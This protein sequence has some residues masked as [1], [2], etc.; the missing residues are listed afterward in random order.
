MLV[1]RKSERD[2]IAQLLDAARLGRTRT[3]VIR[4]EAGIGKSAL[5]AWA[6][7]QA[8]DMRV[9][10]AHG[11]ERDAELPF[12]GLLELCT[13]IL[14]YLDA[15]PERQAAAL[16]SALALGPAVSGDRFTVSAAT[17]GLLAAAAEEKPL[18][19]VIDDAHWLDAASADALL[20]ALRRLAVD[21]IAFLVAVREGEGG[22]FAGLG[23]EELELRGLDAEASSE[24]LSGAVKE[25]LAPGVQQQLQEVAGG[26]PLALLAF[27]AALSS[28]QLAGTEVLPQL[29]P[30]GESLERAFERAAQR[31][32]EPAR[33]TLLLAAANWSEDLEAVRLAAPRLGLTDEALD[34][35]VDSGLARLDGRQLR[36]RHPLVRSS[37]YQAA[38][39]SER[40][41]VHKALADA[42]HD[43]PEERA[44]HRAA[45]TTGADEAVADDLEQVARRAHDRSGYAAAA[46][47]FE[48]AARLSESD[49]HTL[50]RL[51]GGAKA[52]SLAGRPRD[53]TRLLDEAL[54]KGSGSDPK[55][56]AETIGLRG[57]I[58][59]L[60][61]RPEARE[62]LLEAARLIESI[63]P[64]RAV[65]ILADA[66]ES[67]VFAAVPN[68]MLEIATRMQTLAA[69]DDERQQFRTNLALGGA[70]Q[71]SGRYEEGA[72]YL[73]RALEIATE[74]EAITVDP[75][76]LAHA[77]LPATRL[78][79][80][81][82]ASRLARNAIARARAQ[83]A[84]GAL[85]FALRLS[86]GIDASLGG[87]QQAYAAASEGAELARE[88]GQTSQLCGCLAV[89]AHIDAGRG[90][91]AACRQ[92]AREAVDIARQLG[93]RRFRSHAEF[94]LA[95]LELGTGDPRVAAERL[96]PLVDTGAATR[97]AGLKS[98]RSWP[99]ADLVEAYVRAGDI[100]RARETSVLHIAPAEQDDP[101]FQPLAF[102][103][104]GLTAA[105]QEFEHH[106]EAALALHRESQGPFEEARTCLCYGERLRRVG[107]RR[108]A[109]SELRAAL[110]TFETLGAEPW[111]ERAVKELRASGERLH[112]SDPGSAEQLTGQELQIAL[113]VAE[114]RSNR[115][116]AAELFLSPRTVEWHLTRIYRKLDISSR[117]GLIRL[118]ATNRGQDYSAVAASGLRQRGQAEAP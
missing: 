104:R 50:R 3:L 27:A 48:R 84:I 40:R 113:A 82:E 46:A 70:L 94:A 32:S 22:S 98:L 85:P 20:F 95:L 107:Q 12:A 72:R 37:L 71:E 68:E 24:L 108:H 11:A 78:G 5:L 60:D 117:A 62:L 79:R 59:H 57:R 29:L 118:F 38:T 111:A 25:K 44:W 81:E 76:E 47:A 110:E 6:D 43:R 42:L 33:R 64:G 75:Y 15:I 105:D 9:L 30:V 36:F 96:E 28:E 55:L 7:E 92:H 97:R 87:W 80:Q 8:W 41:S 74:S 69:P 35:A 101:L 39:P 86:S 112:R 13:P 58:A 114:G 52:A 109:R 91:E 89:L 2:R 10:R 102:R 103:C 61:A 23:L 4:G 73:A 19:V 31:L 66:L 54:A 51:F 49:A 93:L 115:D 106:F 100:E 53:A 21:N 90:D 45:A 16:R 34:E 65:M 63:D 14:G 99:A 1:G 116:V 26:N 83:S 56:R 17:M 77:C 67:Y 18:L 88:T